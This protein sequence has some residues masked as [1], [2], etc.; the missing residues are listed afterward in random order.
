MDLENTVCSF[1]FVLRLYVTDAAG[2]DGDEMMD[3][4]ELAD[5]IV[6]L[7]ILRRIEGDDNHGVL[8]N[9][10]ILDPLER[11]E[12]VVRDWR[13]A[14]ALID[15]VAANEMDISISHHKLTGMAYVIIQPSGISAMSEY[16]P[17]AICEACVEALS[18]D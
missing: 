8:Y 6:A 12:D 16:T 11:A 1:H 15:I 9:C 5:K 18:D 4:Q 3:D 13:V 7:G 14:G 17:R 10:E 2:T